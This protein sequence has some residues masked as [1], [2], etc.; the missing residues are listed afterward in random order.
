MNNRV[1]IFATVVVALGATLS[2]CGV[3]ARVPG[4][5]YPSM[6][7]RRGALDIQARLE[8]R[9]LSFVNTTPRTLPA[10]RVWLN[11]WYSAPVGETPVGAAVEIPLSAF[12][13]EHG[14]SIRGGGFFASEAPER[15][16]LV[17]RESEDGV[18][19]LIVVG[20]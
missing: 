5:V 1:R 14:E 13:D 15:I 4:E 12:R 7:D 3:P 8:G 17:E 11:A 9:R 19:G 20:P 10:G 2:S 16:T 6:K 18:Y